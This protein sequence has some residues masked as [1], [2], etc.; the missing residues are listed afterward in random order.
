[1]PD[2][3]KKLIIVGS[4]P[5][6]VD[7][8]AFIDSCDCVVRFNNCKN[9]GGN[10][11]TKTDILVLNN[12]GNPDTMDT[13]KF[14]LTPRTPQQ[15]ARDLPYLHTAQKILFARPPVDALIH[16]V[17]TRIPDGPLKQTELTSLKPG[18]NLAADIAAAQQIPAEKICPLPTPQFYSRVWDKLLTFGS[19]P[20]VA[21]STGLI[22]IEMLLADPTWAHHQI[23][24]TG[25]GWNLWKGHPAKLERKLITDYSDTGRIKFLS[26]RRIKLAHWE[27]HR[28][29]ALLLRTLFALHRQ[30]A[31][32]R[33]HHHQ[34]RRLQSFP[35]PKRELK[36]FQML[37]RE[38]P[39]RVPKPFFVKIGANDG[40]A[41]DPCSRILLKNT[42]WC[43]LL[44]EPVPHCFEKLQ[45]NFS[46]PA[47]FTLEPVAIGSKNGTAPFY[48]V[49]PLI[50]E[51][52]PDLPAFFDRIGSFS[53]H[54]VKKH[55]KPELHSFIK[56]RTV[57]V[58]TLTDVLARNAIQKI[59]LLHIDAEGYDFEILKTVDF[60]TLSPTLIFLETNHLTKADLA[61][62]HRLLH[63]HN[64]SVRN[65]GRD[66]LAIHTPT[67]ARLKLRHLT[68]RSDSS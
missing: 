51:A 21:P 52:H 67:A 28:L 7:A 14:M 47:R 43:G 31:S 4:A 9:Y 37:C 57:N 27:Q 68:A 32:L 40:I 1:M 16:F 24:I 10:S 12:A 36:R 45:K 5:L 30:W 23:F 33:L 53:R 60:N 3:P 34:T 19:T 41:N 8:S 63:R 26:K 48:V 17:Q 55:L 38:L 42:A 29:P 22:G 2:T 39:R 35:Q 64:Y 56:E 13:L 46:D 58:S 50:N 44:I 65:A 61:D 15:V 18:R 11:G 54:H 49:D 20:A 6:E 59:D 66:H 25:F 62:M